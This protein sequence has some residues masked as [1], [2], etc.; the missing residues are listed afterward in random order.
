MFYYPRKIVV[1]YE[2]LRIFVKNIT[3]KEVITDRMKYGY[4]MNAN[5]LVMNAKEI[6]MLQ[7]IVIYG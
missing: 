3:G 2:M 4:A 6:C 5:L 7:Q 1:N